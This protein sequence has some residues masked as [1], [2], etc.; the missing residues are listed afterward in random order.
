[1]PQKEAVEQP[2]TRVGGLTHD[3]S[4][5]AGLNVRYAPSLNCDRG[6]LFAASRLISED[7]SR[8]W[9]KLP[10]Y[11]QETA[12]HR[13]QTDNPWGDWG[14]CLQLWY[15]VRECWKGEVRGAPV[16]YWFQAALH[17]GI[18]HSL[19]DLK[20]GK[21][22]WLQIWPNFSHSFWFPFGPPYP[23]VPPSWKWAKYPQGNF[24]Q[25]K[26][27]WGELSTTP[28]CLETLTEGARLLKLHWHTASIQ[29]SK[30]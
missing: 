23:S 19:C 22:I 10:F 30:S 15:G 16:Q 12:I 24:G 7:M 28:S 29:N 18:R 6:W 2:E 17:T 13:T 11:P 1:M 26:T 9:L 27:Q 20:E 8:V 21:R 5:I 3:T 4:V 25:Q 14:N